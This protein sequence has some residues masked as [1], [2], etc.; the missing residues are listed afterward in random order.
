MCTSFSNLNAE[1]F[2]DRQH[3]GGGG[4][5]PPPLA[6]EGNENTGQVRLTKLINVLETSKLRIRGHNLDFASYVLLNF[7]TLRLFENLAPC[8]YV[9]KRVSCDH[10]FFALC[11]FG[12]PYCTLVGPSYQSHNYPFSLHGIYQLN[13]AFTLPLLGG[14]RKS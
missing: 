12:R 9:T 3:K 10:F 2:L 14:G 6:A 7:L 13:W 8:T 1:F 4:K 5:L 11:C